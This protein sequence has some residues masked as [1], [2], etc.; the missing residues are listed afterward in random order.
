MGKI[1][2]LLGGALLLVAGT[3]FAEDQLGDEFTAAALDEFT[4]AAPKEFA[5]LTENERAEY[6]EL[7]VDCGAYVE[8]FDNA[9]DFK[10]MCEAK[11]EVFTRYRKTSAITLLFER[12]I[13]FGGDQSCSP[14]QCVRP[15]KNAMAA[16]RK[17]YRDYRDASGDTTTPSGYKAY[18]KA[19]KE[20]DEEPSA[21]QILIPL[22]RQGGA[23]IIPVQINKAITLNFVVDSGAAD[24]SIPADVVS[25]LIRTG[26]LQETDFIGKQNYKLADGSTIPSPTFRVRSLTVNKVEITNVKASVAPAAGELLLGQSFLSR[27]KSWSIDNARQALVLTQ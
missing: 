25:T 3:C 16:L 12:A 17:I 14:R 20:M 4:A 8:G 9:A 15:G 23:F 11:F 13:S 21:T 19:M 26:T 27:F 5:A 18:V 10:E 6:K 24:V 7:L 1:R 2:A 22:Q